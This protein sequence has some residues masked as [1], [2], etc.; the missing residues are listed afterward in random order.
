MT[1]ILKTLSAAALL[2]FVSASASAQDIQL[3]ETHTLP[4]N[5]EEQ[6]ASQ[7]YQ[8]TDS[9]EPESSLP[10]LP[11]EE[12][13]PVKQKPVGMFS[14]GLE[15]NT[16]FYVADPTIGT[17]VDH[18]VGSNN[19]LKADYMYGRF[20]VGL[21]LEYYPYPLKGYEKALRGIGLTGKYV[22]WTDRNYSITLG[23]YYEQFGSGLVLRTWEDRD[24]GI[25]NSLGGA[26]I[27]F[28]ALDNAIEGRVVAGLPRY[29]LNSK[30]AGYGWFQR[31]GDDYAH[32]LSPGGPLSR[33]LVSGGDLSI[34]LTRLIAPESE[35]NFS[36][37]GSV[38][39]RYEFE[40][41][42]EIED[43]AEKNGFTVP[44]NVLSY[45][46]RMAYSWRDLSVKAEYVGKSNDYSKNHRTDKYEL[47]RGNAQLVEIN[48]S[49][50]GFAGALT[51]R[52]LSNMQDKIFRGVESVTAGNTLNYLPALCQQQTYMLAS[53]NP[54]STYADGEMG[55]QIDLY[56]N[57][58]RGSKVGGKYGMKFHVNASMIYSL[59]GALPEKYTKPRLGYRDITMD[60]EKVWTKKFKT[61]LLVSIQ[62]YSPSHGSSKATEA[63][64]AFVLD[65]QY[66]FT[67][68]FSL[69]GELQYLY[70]QELT[71]DWMAALIEASIAPHWN[72][73][74][75][76]MYNHGSTKVHY[77][78]AGVSFSHS[79][80]RIAASYGRNREGMVCSGGVCRYQPAYTG[81][82]IQLSLSF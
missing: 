17:T 47:M 20:S 19:F 49:N 16:I 57:F 8:N 4:V 60:L 10:E 26:R 82:N 38:V 62:E 68:R 66:K 5:S 64:N 43:F 74:V 75:S 18:L 80:L 51:L 37:E 7:L 77:Y 69:R 44:K 28:N 2:T 53:L 41:P 70:S 9:A 14:G 12:Y 55:G 30:G 27:T 81:G 76:D 56:Y 72:I 63:Q 73:F 6:E 32:P 42:V 31:F 48:Y 23:D 22:A 50:G 67:P 35:H 13:A 46:A 61:V 39:S 25:N 33:T 71:K 58:R 21:Q 3:Q 1:K 54:C 59:P 15:S 11:E 34:S 78:S 29:Y 45:S 40:T 52:R 65:L 24:L 79:F 36:I